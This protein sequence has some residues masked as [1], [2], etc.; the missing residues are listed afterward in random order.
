MDVDDKENTKRRSY[1]PLNLLLISKEFS[2][3]VAKLA[4]TITK[5]DFDPE[6][7]YNEL[8][9][10][11]SDLLVKLDAIEDKVL[12]TIWFESTTKPATIH[13]FEE[14]KRRMGMKRSNRL[15]LERIRAKAQASQHK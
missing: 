8:K 15:T 6:K 9:D 5:G 11:R 14:W 4:I 2:N 7:T 1:W 13:N 10:A 12:E 3:A